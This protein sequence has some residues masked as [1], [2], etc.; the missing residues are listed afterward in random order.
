MLV[1]DCAS[2]QAER[3]SVCGLHPGGP[4]EFSPQL[5]IL[6]QHLLGRGSRH[7]L[8]DRPSLRDPCWTGGRPWEN[9][10][11]ELKWLLG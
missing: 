11:Q 9:V 7:Q 3:A 2:V 5:R 4:A 8:C 10:K 6:A 1:E